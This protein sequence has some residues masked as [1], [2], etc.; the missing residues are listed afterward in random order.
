MV[1][2]Y[3]DKNSTVGSLDRRIFGATHACKTWTMSHA[4]NR[5][6][7]RTSVDFDR[8]KFFTMQVFDDDASC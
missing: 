1:A 2:R 4:T 8:S 7:H 6:F 3:D 5:P